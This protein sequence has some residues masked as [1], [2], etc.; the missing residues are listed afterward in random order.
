MGVYPPESVLAYATFL[1]WAHVLIILGDARRVMAAVDPALVVAQEQGLVARVI[2]LSLVQALAHNVLGESRRSLEALDRALAAAEPA[3]YLRTFDQGEGIRKLLAEAAAR[4]VRRRQIHGILDVI[5]RPAAPPA[6]APPAAPPVQA[7]MADGKAPA[8]AQADGR[9]PAGEWVE[10]LSAREQ[11]ILELIAA[12]LS[13]AEIAAR[14]V[15]GIGTVKT[16]VNHLFGKLDAGSR[17]QLLARARVLR[18]I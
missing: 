8:Q 1:A 11:E 13:N 12:G 7:E 5:G 9:P 10:P 16:H 3:G 15:I 4:G 14:L 17:T 2:E 18:L 6:G